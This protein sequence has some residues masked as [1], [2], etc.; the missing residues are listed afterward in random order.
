MGSLPFRALPG[1][2]RA[3]D[4]LEL[5]HVLG[6]FGVRGEVRIFLHNPTSGLWRAPVD[7]VLVA[8]DGQRHAVQLKVRP[9]AGKRILARLGALDDRDVAASLRD[10]R[11]VLARAALP[12]PAPGEFYL[13][14]VIGADVI[15]EGQRVGSLVDVQTTDVGEVLEVDAPGGPWFVPCVKAWVLEVDAAGGRVVLAPGALSEE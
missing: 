1:R 13:W 2:G 14:Q 9:G 10:W 15:V 7:V 11:I 3:D 12:A 4:E 5:G 8:P 6:A